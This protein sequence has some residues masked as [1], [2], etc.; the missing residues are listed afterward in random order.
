MQA[1]ARGEIHVHR[2]LNFAPLS[3]NV[4]VEVKLQS[5]DILDGTLGKG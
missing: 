1:N 4:R 5:R 3:N 2:S